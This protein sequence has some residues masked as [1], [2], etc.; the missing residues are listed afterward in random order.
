MPRGQQGPSQRG[1]WRDVD[2]P[3]RDTGGRTSRRGA[4]PLAT[5]AGQFARAADRV[6]E[7]GDALIVARTSDGGAYAFTLLTREGRKKAYAASE[8]ELC[9]LIDGL[10]E[11]YPAEEK[12]S[13]TRVRPKIS[14]QPTSQGS[15]DLERLKADR[16]GFLERLKGSQMQVEAEQAAAVD[17]AT[18]R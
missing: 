8:E 18:R 6:T 13:E 7:A 3:G 4:P 2:P 1:A 12:S 17:G 5:I 16:T 11:E 15:G 9:L 10:L 14:T